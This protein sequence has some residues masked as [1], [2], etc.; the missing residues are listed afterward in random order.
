MLGRALVVTGGRGSNRLVTIYYLQGQGQSSAHSFTAFNNAPVSTGS[1]RAV[2]GSAVAGGTTIAAVGDV[3]DDGSC[4][5][6]V[7]QAAPAG[8]RPRDALEIYHISPDGSTQLTAQL[9]AFDGSGI[10]NSSNFVVGDVDP[11]VP[12]DEIVVGEDGV[13]RQAARIRIFG[14]VT[15]G[16]ARLL[17]QFRGL[18]TSGAMRQ[19]LPLALGNVLSDASHPGKS[20]VI[21]DARGHVY[22]YGVR[23]GRVS[24]LRRFAAFPDAPR[25]S[26][27]RLGVGDLLS[28]NPGDE[29]VVGDDGTRQDGLVRVL[30]GRSGQMLLELE[31]FE[32]G[33][34]VAGVDLWVADVI[35]ELPGAELIVASSGKVRVFS[36]SGGVPRHVFDLID[37]SRGTAS[38]RGLLAVGQLVP[39]APGNQVAVAATDPH[40]PVQVFH[41]DENGATLMDELLMPDA[42]P[43]VSIGTIA[44]AP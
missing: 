32:P 34:A 26:A 6:V 20:I 24:L 40:Q 9:A 18:P 43:D 10:A 8:E 29:I 22:V 41:F 4:N 12:G 15:T 39:D 2:D 21:G 1:R 17:F 13:R 23:S 42:G 25:T 16:A 36:L 3:Q 30:D 38:L 35:P 27:R 19:P 44:I 28:N 7:G 31:A 14:G 37:S 33:Q 11:S 5:L